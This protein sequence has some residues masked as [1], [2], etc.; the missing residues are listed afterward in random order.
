MLQAKKAEANSGI[1]MKN[2]D[3]M[4][5]LIGA[6]TE[7]SP[8]AS[9]WG[10]KEAE[11]G[12]IPKQ[13]LTDSEIMGNAFVFTLAGHE[14]TANVIHYSLVLLAMHPSSQRRLQA[15]LD[16]IFR[17]RPISEWDYERD[18]PKLFGGMCGAVLNE[19]LRLIP[20]APSIPKCTLETPQD[21]IINGKKHTISPHTYIGLIATAVHRNPNYWPHGPPTDPEHPVH[22][23]SNTDNDLEEFKPERWLLEPQK[24][25]VKHESLPRPAP[26][27]TEPESA[28]GINVAPDTSPAL[29]RPI[30]GAYIPFSEG[31]RACLGRRFAQVEVLA[32]L[33]VILSQYSV[34]L[35]LDADGEDGERG[36]SDEELDAMSEVEVREL[37][38][39]KKRG[40]WKLMRTRMATIITLQLRGCHVPL[41][42][43]KRGGE[44]VPW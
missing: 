31:H 24:P 20:V 33:A 11:E 16:A 1:K 40:L 2:L 7:E 5:A 17:G 18:L 34:E 22:P 10:E 42:F 26:T 23:T 3:L 32:V 15:D 39:R 29:Y 8:T 30:R 41:R 21:I 25:T 37:W 36:V 19:E 6:G 14:S 35:A 13:A 38:E 27:S 12:A 28:L 9:S 4:G 44:R 43:V